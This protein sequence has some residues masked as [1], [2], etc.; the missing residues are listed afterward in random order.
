MPKGKNHQKVEWRIK[1]PQKML[2]TA[3]TYVWYEQMMIPVLQ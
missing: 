1:Y 2:I 3:M